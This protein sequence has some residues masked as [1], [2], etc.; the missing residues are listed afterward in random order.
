MKIN[1]LTKPRL[2][3]QARVALSLPL[4]F[5]LFLQTNSARGA[6][7]QRRSIRISSPS[8]STRV[9]HTFSFNNPTAGVIGSISFEY[10]D[11]PLINVPC[12]ASPGL[13]VS[14][15]TLGAQTGNAGFARDASTTTNKLVISRTPSGTLSTNNS[16]VVDNVLNPS[17][18]DR[19]YF[20]RIS[21]YSS[22]DGSG[23]P[24][25]R[26]SVAFVTSGSFNIGAYVPPFLIFCVGVTVAPDC[27]SATGNLVNFG[28]LDPNV[29]AL[30]TTQFAGA[31]ND[32]SGYQVFVNGTTMTS[33]NNIIPALTS[34][35]ASA[36]GTSQFGM[37]LRLNSNPSVGSNPSGSGTTA[38]DSKYATPNQFVFGNGDLLVKS[39]TSTNFNVFT[40]SYLVNVSADQKAGVYATTLLYTALASF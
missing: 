12:A 3:K 28:V 33:G 18:A 39:T 32:F 34:P 26:G 4:V 8:I 22:N 5:L 19:T 13:D 15:A 29:P 14:T 40:Q 21:T 27:S 1:F 36:K 10:C 37:N 31:T 17:V 20:V 7:L 11:S 38:I 23:A 6:D 9:R 24:T 35:A 2:A 25:D 16:Y 30:A